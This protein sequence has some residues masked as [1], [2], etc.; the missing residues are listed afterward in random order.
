MR[1]D[2]LSLPND[3]PPAAKALAQAAI[4]DDRDAFAL[5]MEA[6]HWPSC[7]IAP[8][9][10]LRLL[11]EGR[12]LGLLRLAQAKLGSDHNG[13][14]PLSICIGRGDADTLLGLQGSYDPNAPM[15]GASLAVL[16]VRSD[17][18]DIVRCL[19][20]SG[21]D[22]NTVDERGAPAF[23]S[24]VNRCNGPAILS[25]FAEAGAN[26]AATDSAG[27]DILILAID[28]GDPEMISAAIG[29]GTPGLIDC[30]PSTAMSRALSSRR[31]S[32]ARDLARAGHPLCAK[33]GGTVCD[34]ALPAFEALACAPGGP[35]R[36]LLEIAFASMDDAELAE[37][38]ETAAASPKFALAL[39]LAET[40]TV[41]RASARMENPAPCEFQKKPRI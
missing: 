5:A 33:N 24:A 20:K 27:R 11:F 31:F 30:R 37:T 22:P 2:S 39:A 34:S 32:C 38:A 12:R 8:L 21:M 41:R 18:P 26:M 9:K 40:E 15:R 23:F 13:P 10:I 14:T 29:Y 19:L 36:E 28:E 3:L 25:A 4:D 1:A 6:G 7:P 17:K 16:A 35:A